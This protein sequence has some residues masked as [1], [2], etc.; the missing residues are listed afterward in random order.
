MHQRSLLLLALTACSFPDVNVIGA[1]G[2][3][4][5]ISSSMSSSSSTSSSGTM[6]GAGGA[7]VGGAG[8]TGGVICVDGDGDGQLPL[9]CDGGTDCDD[10]DKNAFDGQTLGFGVPRNGGG[11]DYDCD[12][13]ETLFLMQRSMC[14]TGCLQ[15]GKW[16][17]DA[18]ACGVP[19]ITF[20]CATIAGMCVT[21]SEP[22]P[23]I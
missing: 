23:C 10:T 5:E 17:K 6:G 3:G 21:D 22:N 13:Q 20:E 1:G 9:G 15:T 4:G 19:V 11:F 14:P 8:G 7:M 16:Y 18:V 2:E 12:G